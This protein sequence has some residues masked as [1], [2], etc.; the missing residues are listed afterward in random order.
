M[1]TVTMAVLLNT[2]MLA[3]NIA[4]TGDMR[5]GDDIDGGVHADN[6]Y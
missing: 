5:I 2:V 3:N 1:L 4:A 6:E